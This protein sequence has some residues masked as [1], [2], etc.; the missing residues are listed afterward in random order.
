VGGLARSFPRETI[1]GRHDL[2]TT[3]PEENSVTMAVMADTQ[4]LELDVQGCSAG[5]FI[6]VVRGQPVIAVFPTSPRG[7]QRHS[8]DHNA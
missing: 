2:L 3:T 6:W 7:A 1:L 5:S 4:Q 8:L